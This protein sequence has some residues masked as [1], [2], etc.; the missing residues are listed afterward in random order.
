MLARKYFLDGNSEIAGCGRG[1]KLATSGTFPT[2]SLNETK[3]IRRDDRFEL[4][5][6]YSVSMKFLL[7]FLITHPLPI[8]FLLF[9][10]AND[11]L[12]I[13]R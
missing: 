7:R 5:M 8:S 2:R 11:I 6:N 10:V 12:S 1:S 13:N 9:I 4:F 3:E